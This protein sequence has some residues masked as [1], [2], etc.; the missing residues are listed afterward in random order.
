M[1]ARGAP[2]HKSFL[3]L[4]FK[5]EVLPS[6]SFCCSASSLAPHAVWPTNLNHI[7][8]YTKY[9]RRRSNVLEAA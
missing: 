2:G 3:L 6:F 5:K 8:P 9:I 4:F 7:I 1:P